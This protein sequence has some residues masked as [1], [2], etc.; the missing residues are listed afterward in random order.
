M[1]TLCGNELPTTIYNSTDN[2][3]LVVM[4]TDSSIENKGFSAKFRTVT[5]RENLLFIVAIH[6]TVCLVQACGGTIMVNETGTIDMDSFHGME[7]R[8]CNW[9]L[10]APKPGE[11]HSLRYS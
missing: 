3:M 6:R 8:N 5:I 2:K 10:I 11:I 9:T 7:E 1:A 4:Q